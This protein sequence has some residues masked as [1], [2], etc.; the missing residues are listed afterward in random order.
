MKTDMVIHTAKTDMVIYT[1]KI[2]MMKLV[3]EIEC[4]G[5]NADEF[6]KETGSSNG[7]QPKQVDLNCIHALNE[8][9]LHEIHVVPSRDRASL[10]VVVGSS[11]ISYYSSLFKIMPPRMTTRNAGR[12][13]AAPRGG[14]M[15]GQT[16]RGGGRTGEQMGRGGRRT[17]DHI[18]NQGINE[19]RNDNA[20]D[21]IIHEDVRNVNVSNNGSGCSYK[22]FV[23]CKPKEFDGKGGA[24]SYT[25]WVEKMEAVQDIS[26]C[27][28]NQ[29]VKY[30]D[31]SLTGKALTWWNTQKL[32]TE[33]WCHTMVGAGHA[34]YTD[35]FY[36]L[37]RLVPHLVTLETKRI[38][39]VV[40]EEEMAESQVNRNVKGDNKRERNGKGGTQ[41]GDSTECLKSNSSS[42]GGNH[43]NQ[44]LAI[45]G[46][47]GHGNNG[48]RTCGRAF[49]MGAEEAH[50]DPN[51]MTEWP[52]EKVKHLMS[53]KAEEQKLK[54]IAVVQSFFKLCASF[55]AHY[56]R[57]CRSPILWEEI[58]EGQ[59]I[60][61]DIIQE[62]TKKISYI[63]DR[64]KATR[65]RQ[66]S[67]ADKQRKPLEF[68]AGDCVLLKV[69]PWKGV[70]HF[71][72]MEN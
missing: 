12:Q 55:E 69:S 36:E 6:D 63:K 70:V 57:K 11:Y 61:P 21:V 51:I 4:V 19:S 17:G 31:G 2:E 28:V 59:L 52:K 16:G 35:R 8:P 24:I 42:Q 67:Y 1:T 7:L 20:A 34:A 71:G 43:S 49:V 58:R 5:M 3:V 25:R 68:I 27:E 53:A 32:E 72:R 30:A 64:L 60:G 37:V 22:E 39:R 13:T 18:S 10:H 9:H 48:I 45:K 50:Q 46:G 29:K 54:D 56:K 33:F 44:A 47:Q 65:N 26:G 41:D 38:K 23:A 40:R 62:T 66:K 15:G 14:R